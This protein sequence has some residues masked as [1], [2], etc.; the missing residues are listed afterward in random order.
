MQP[1]TKQ[2]HSPIPALI[3]RK[4]AGAG[5]GNGGGGVDEAEEVEVNIFVCVSVK[6]SQNHMLY[7]F[8]GHNRPEKCNICVLLLFSAR[9]V[10]AA[11]AKKWRD[12]RHSTTHMTLNPQWAKSFRPGML[13]LCQISYFQSTQATM[14]LIRKLPF[15]ILVHEIA[16]DYKTDLR[17][18]ATAIPTLHHALE[19]F[20]VEVMEKTHLAAL[21]HKRITIA[22]KDMHLL[23][24]VTHM[25]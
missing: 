2:P 14:F 7:L 21:H 9:K 25:W 20:L 19:Y 18:T 12:A 6:I 23:K 10:L 5:G 24:A 15:A 1:G 4:G 8:F 17:F 22:P 13:A 16:Q 11:Q 3:L